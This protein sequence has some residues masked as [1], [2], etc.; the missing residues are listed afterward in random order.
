MLRQVRPNAL[1]SLQHQ[2]AT[3]LLEQCHSFHFDWDT[4]KY[5]FA[6]NTASPHLHRFNE[7]TGKE[8][9]EFAVLR[10][11]IAYLVDTTKETLEGRSDASH[12]DVIRELG[13]YLEWMIRKA[14]ELKTGLEGEGHRYRDGKPQFKVLGTS[15][16]PADGDAMDCDRS[17]GMFEL[18]SAFASFQKPS[19]PVR[20]S[21]T[22]E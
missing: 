1:R 7:I 5:E 6:P 14:K 11:K 18:R 16:E 8:D 22:S 20:Q 4:L 13:S 21:F 2:Q 12:T 17:S 10:D 9:Y 3:D 19:T 15:K